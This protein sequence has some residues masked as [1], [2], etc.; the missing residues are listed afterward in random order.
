MGRSG[1]SLKGLTKA[2]E[3]L[4]FQ[5]SPVRASL[6]RLVAQTNPWIAHWEGNHYVVVYRCQGDRILIADPAVGKRVV[7]RTEFLSSWTGYALLL[8]PTAQLAATPDDKTSLNRYWGLLWP[9]RSII[10]QILLLSLLLQV[11]S[12]I[13]PLFTQIIL[14]RVIVNKSWITLQVFAI[15]LLLFGI[16]SIALTA[17]RQYLLDY[18]SNR[19]D[20]TFLSGFINHTLRLPLKFFESRQ[21]GDII[22][23]VQETRKIQTFLTRQAVLTWLDA[24]MVFVYVG[25]MVY[26]NWQLTLLVLVLIPPIVILT[27]VASPLLRQLSREIFNEDASQNSLINYSGL[28]SG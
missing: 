19:L 20:L 28:P 21:V 27:V 5:A 17:T 15:G 2:A 1:A 11:F 13:T 6:S 9:Y 25:L 23:R 18:F 8:D 7:S 26:Y 16:W 22:T 24:L 12:L 3:S 14:D 4:G 10:G